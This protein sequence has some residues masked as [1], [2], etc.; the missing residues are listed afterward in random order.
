[1][2]N[3]S[4]KIDCVTV[5]LSKLYPAVWLATSQNTSL[6]NKELTN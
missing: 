6:L 4:D 3:V 2:N 1:M 5:L